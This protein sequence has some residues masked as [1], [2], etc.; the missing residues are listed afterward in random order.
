[1]S[2]ASSVLPTMSGGGGGVIY[3]RIGSFC[4]YW[5]DGCDGGNGEE[6]RE[7]RCRISIKDWMG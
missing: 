7:E 6:S 5:K 2:F 1:M 4:I 3:D